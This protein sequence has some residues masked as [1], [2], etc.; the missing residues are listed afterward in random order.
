[1]RKN[2]ILLTIL[3]CLSCILQAAGSGND[4]RHYV[5]SRFPKVRPDFTTLFVSPAPGKETTFFRNVSQNRIPGEL[6]LVSCTPV[7]SY[8]IKSNT[9]KTPDKSISSAIREIPEAIVWS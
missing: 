3:C 5:K 2:F 7:N 6:E 8:L 4:Y 9:I 1:M